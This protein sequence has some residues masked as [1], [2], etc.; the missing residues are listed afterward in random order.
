MMLDHVD[1]DVMLTHAPV[2]MRLDVIA[3]KPTLLAAPFPAQEEIA[4]D[5]HGSDW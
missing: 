3:A 4:Q 5:D 1:F 2:P